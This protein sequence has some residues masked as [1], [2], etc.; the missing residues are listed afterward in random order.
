MAAIRPKTYNSKLIYD[1][2]RQENIDPALLTSYASSIIFDEQKRVLWHRGHQYG[3]TYYGSD[4]GETFNDYA[5]NN[6]SGQYSHAQGTM[7]S[8]TG[9][10]A[11][12]EGIG[13][14]ANGMGS[15]AQGSH[16][17]ASGRFSLA[18]GINTK[19]TSDGE[20]A[21]GTF[22]VSESDR[23][24]LFA[25]G[26]GN[27]DDSRHNIIE[28]NKDCAYVGNPAYFG[29]YIYAPLT[30]SYTYY[31]GNKPLD[32]I[33]EGLLD[34]AVY[35]KPV[36]YTTITGIAPSGYSDITFVENR[37][38]YHG[39]TDESNVIVANSDEIITYM[40]I[41]SYF[42]P[43]VKVDWWYIPQT[44]ITNHN[45]IK[46]NNPLATCTS[47]FDVIL[48]VEE[49]YQLPPYR[50][51]LSKG[52]NKEDPKMLS[53]NYINSSTWSSAVAETGANSEMSSQ[54]VGLSAIFYSSMLS[55]P[56]F[57]YIKSTN[58]YNVVANISMSYLESTYMVYEQLRRVGLTQISYGY[59]VS[60]NATGDI[61]P[62]NIPADGISPWFGKGRMNIPQKLIVKGRY[63]CFYG[64]TNSIFLNIIIPSG[65]TDTVRRTFDDDNYTFLN[66]DG[67]TEIV[68]NITD[69]ERALVN[70]ATPDN[71]IYFYIAYPYIYNHKANGYKGKYNVNYKNGDGQNNEMVHDNTT[72]K[73][74]NLLPL[75]M[76]NSD[77]NIAINYIIL[78]IKL[79]NDIFGDY[80]NSVV[81]FCI[82]KTANVSDRDLILTEDETPY[83][84]DQSV[85]AKMQH[86]GI[87][88]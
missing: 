10:A 37:A 64:V 39:T 57:T 17:N 46:N 67:I 76:N 49:F 85:T 59:K 82:E 12:A 88:K 2:E 1:Y 25:I 44:D 79:T 51:G 75:G 11:S 61:Y 26:N 43:N 53:C 86:D 87:G 48:P 19:T 55:S 16:T 6:A 73:T 33:I 29:D 5:N 68:H 77:P 23:N 62:D 34:E 8:A 83:G 70:G 36:V 47:S 71:P 58:D 69:K 40:E 41:G 72:F 84:I 3:N 4:H 20:A 52:W 81:R 28:V 27:D 56:N 31:T 65:A 60:D 35:R 78:S 7:T 74:I 15:H 13:T 18:S 38:S 22:N 32:K 80:D 24:I 9:T 42:N 45:V 30:Y 54:D 14:V 50:T 66:K 63:K 21:F